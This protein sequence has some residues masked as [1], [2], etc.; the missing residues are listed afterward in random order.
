MPPPV[1][2]GPPGM[3]HVTLDQEYVRK[4]VES[5]EQVNVEEKRDIGC[6]GYLY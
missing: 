4:K 6:P 5:G 2:T 1:A 3:M